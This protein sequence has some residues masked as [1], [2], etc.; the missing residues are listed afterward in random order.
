MTL[1]DTP[2]VSASEPAAPEH[3]RA[4]RLLGYPAVLGALAALATLVPILGLTLLAVG[5]DHR[6]S[7]GAE[8]A[9][10]VGAS[11]WLAVHGAGVVADGLTVDVL[12]L[13][14]LAVPVLAGTAGALR[15]V[16]GA[17]ER[18]GRI[19]VSLGQFWLGY[20]AC[21]AAALALSLA[22]PARP[23]WW[24][25][26][27]A[28]VLVPGLAI[29][30]ALWRGTRSGHFS[31][32]VTVRGRTLPA[33]LQRGVIPALRGI[34]TLLLIGS[35]AVVV[36]VVLHR[37]KVLAVQAV[38]TPGVVG[39]VLLWLLQL[40]AL[41]NLGIW[42]VS[43]AAGPGFVPVSG[44]GVSWSGTHASVLPL[45]PVFGALP[46]EAAYPPVVAAV[47][48]IPVVVGWRLGR[49]AL[50]TVPRLSA[51]R[52]K[53]SIALSASA[54]CAAGVGL[55]ALVGGSN[56]GTHRLAGIGPPVHWLVLVLAGEL[57]L[58]ALLAVTWDA[59]RLRR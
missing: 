51:L 45:V 16:R 23:V 31:G 36:L 4:R 43:F 17:G 56:L 15:V 24:R 38:L 59:W 44:A 49:D 33:S 27:V 25:L 32:T 1:L 37:D 5:G 54:L 9:L 29:L 21:L 28:A 12:P 57:L 42:A 14:L 2:P 8:Q 47:V 58:G 40:G 55:L 18:S 41:P 19:G 53:A 20:A 22:G 52:T 7:V 10:G 13:L 6:S 35:L 46:G 50:K 34:A 48:L 39:G 26:A 3:R 30:L 11:I